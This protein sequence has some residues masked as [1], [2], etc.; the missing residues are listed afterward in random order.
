[1]ETFTGLV[2]WFSDAKGYGFIMPD[3][4]GEDVF[5]HYTGITKQEGVTFKTI[6]QGAKVSYNLTPGI[7]GTQAGMI[8][9]DVSPVQS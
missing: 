5:V 8:A 3:N 1:M 2:K 4:G 7:K 9:V 6:P